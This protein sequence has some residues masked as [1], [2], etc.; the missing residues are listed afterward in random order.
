MLNNIVF[1]TKKSFETN[2]SNVLKASEMT[3]VKNYK[4]LRDIFLEE[5]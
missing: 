2:L 1:K 4:Y 3:L 5:L